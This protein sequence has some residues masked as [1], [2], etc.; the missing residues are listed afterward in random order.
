MTGFDEVIRAL[1]KDP[2]KRFARS[3]WNGKGMFIY[4]TPGSVVE[5]ENWHDPDTLTEDEVM[6]GVVKILPHIDMC[7]ADGSRVI[8][9][10]ASQTDMLS[11]DWEEVEGQA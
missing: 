11:D 3:G 7:A 9:W 8:G 5:A 6:A 2:T 10:L 4:L 1:K